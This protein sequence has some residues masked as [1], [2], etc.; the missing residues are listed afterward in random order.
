MYNIVFAVLLRI[1]LRTKR[2]QTN[3]QKRKKK[4]EKCIYQLLIATLVYMLFRS[5]EAIPPFRSIS[6]E[7]ALFACI[8]AVSVCICSYMYICLSST[9]I[10]AFL[11]F[12]VAAVVVA[13][14]TVCFSREII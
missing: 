9:S 14:V 5:T 3:E 7:R 11:V 6:I 2:T 8:C 10:C 4:S 12:R 1:A 13:A